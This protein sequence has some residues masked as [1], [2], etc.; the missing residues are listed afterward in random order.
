MSPTSSSVSSLRIRPWEQDGE[1]LKLRPKEETGE[2]QRR[3]Q[4]GG[5]EAVTRFIPRHWIHTQSSN[6][7][8]DLTTIRR[9]PE[10]EAQGGSEEALAQHGEE[11]DERGD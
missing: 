11:L 2:K 4:T 8:L 10:K 3:L 7:S 5:E 6:W 9:E 1:D